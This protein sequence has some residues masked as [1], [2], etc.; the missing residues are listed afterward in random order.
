[1]DWQLELTLAGRALLAGLLGG[2]VGLE[3]QWH[4]REAGIRT[5]AAVS[6]GA[7]VAAL[8]ATHV[9]TGNNPHVISANVVSGIGFLGAGVIIRDHGGIAGLTTAA[10]LWATATIGLSIGY[11]M[12]VLGVLVTALIFCILALHHV[13]GWHQLNPSS[14]S[15]KKRMPSPSAVSEDS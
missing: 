10:S 13:P 8:V 6:L 7:C 4:G 14:E 11:G 2:L 9:S 5:Y 15:H 12:L 3:R 1:M